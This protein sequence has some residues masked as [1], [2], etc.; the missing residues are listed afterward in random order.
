MRKI[1]FYFLSVYW[2]LTTYCIFEIFLV[3]KVHTYGTLCTAGTG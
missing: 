3:K 2:I 1:L